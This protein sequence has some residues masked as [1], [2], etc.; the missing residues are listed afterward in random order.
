MINVKLIAHTCDLVRGDLESVVAYA[1]KL[2]YSKSNIEDL[3]QNQDDEKIEKFINNLLDIG[4]ESPLEHVSFTFGIEGISRACSHQ[5]VRHRIASY[6][7]QSQRYVDLNSTYNYITPP[8]ILEDDEINNFYTEINDII[9]EKY[10]VLTKM[11]EE[12]HIKNGMDKK[13]ANKKAIEDARFILPNACETKIMV[14]M[15]VRTLH[16]FFKE[17]C[18][19]RA[20]WEIREV[21]NKML[22]ICL[23]VAPLLFKKAG[24]TCAFG[25]CKEGKMSCRNK[26]IPREKQKILNNSNKENK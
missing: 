14:T 10:K 9:F 13:S 2:C 15:N 7:Q 22:D 12:K 17:R 16:N 6:S 26:V 11:L 3:I 5:L 4:H 19:N 20:Q 24:P 23:D 18:C 1:A 8:S 21:A 25:K